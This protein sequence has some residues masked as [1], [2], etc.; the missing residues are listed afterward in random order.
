MKEIP[1]AAGSLFYEFVQTDKIPQFLAYV[2]YDSL[3]RSGSA[4]TFVPV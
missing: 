2:F 3:G 4:L 1:P